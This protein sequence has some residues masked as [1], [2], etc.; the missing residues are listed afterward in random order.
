ML[1]IEPGLGTTRPRP[2][3]GVSPPIPKAIAYAAVRPNAGG[4]GVL[5]CASA[6]GAG[7]AVLV[8]AYGA[9]DGAADGR[10]PPGLDS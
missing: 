3:A 2:P 4:G 8:G 5:C 9:V 1:S 7:M 6:G 10:T